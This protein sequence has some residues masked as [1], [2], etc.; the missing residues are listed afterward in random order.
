MTAFRRSGVTPLDT[1]TRPPLCR[2]PLLCYYKSIDCMMVCRCAM[3][4]FWRTARSIALAHACSCRSICH[5]CTRKRAL[6]GHSTCCRRTQDTIDEGTMRRRGGVLYTWPVDYPD[7]ATRVGVSE[8]GCRCLVGICTNANCS[9]API[10][11]SRSCPR[12]L[13]MPRAS[14][15]GASDSRVLKREDARGRQLVKLIEW[16]KNDG[17]LCRQ[18]QARLRVVLLGNGCVQHSPSASRQPRQPLAAS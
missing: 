7:G 2:R 6:D 5:G 16:A 11:L 15:Q 17:G 12:W 8:M 14:R 9:M 10:A 4:T 3:D 13:T 18:H 1:R